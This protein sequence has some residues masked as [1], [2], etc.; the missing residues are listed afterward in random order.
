L[1]Y[2]NISKTASDAILTDT[3]AIN[4]NFAGSGDA[5]VSVGINVKLKFF[6]QYF[7][8]KFKFGGNA[9]GTLVLYSSVG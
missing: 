7:L 9:A 3:K 2:F 8:Q 1:P 5:I 6:V 4:P